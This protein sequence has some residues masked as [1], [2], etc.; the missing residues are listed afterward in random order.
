MDDE[1]LMHAV[2]SVTVAAFVAFVVHLMLGDDDK[3]KRR[4]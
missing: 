3:P 1:T 4:K 2:I